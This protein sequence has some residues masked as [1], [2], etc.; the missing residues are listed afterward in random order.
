MFFRQHFGESAS[1]Y[2]RRLASY[3]IP[4]GG[5]RVKIAKSAILRNRPKKPEPGRV[6]VFRGEDLQQFQDIPNPFRRKGIK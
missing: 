3:S 4:T 1:D 5:R 6:R 2:S